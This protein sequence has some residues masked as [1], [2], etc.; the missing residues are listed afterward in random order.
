MSA[1]VAME[2]LERFDPDLKRRRQERERLLKEQEE[3]REM[4]QLRRLSYAPHPQY[5]LAYR[6]H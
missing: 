4:E 5:V 6:N 2:L 3:R 1:Q